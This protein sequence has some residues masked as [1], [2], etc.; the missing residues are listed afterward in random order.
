M[1]EVRYEEVVADFAGQARRITEYLGLAW[2]DACL[3]F[4]ETARP[5]R[6][7]SASQVRKPIYATSTNRWRKYEQYLSPLLEELGPLVAEYEAEI[8]HLMATP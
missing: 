3:K 4:H 7:A 1:L 5:V 8:A 2:D 6:T